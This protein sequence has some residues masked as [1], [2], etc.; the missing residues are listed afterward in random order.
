MNGHVV[1]TGGAGRLGR[2]VVE[3]LVAA[4][5]RVLSVDVVRPE[6][7]PGPFVQADITSA[8]EVHDL[9]AGADSVIHLAAVPGP[10]MRPASA[11]FDINVRSTFNIAQAAVAHRLG[12]IVFASSVFTLGWHEA[13]DGYWPQY[14]PVDEAHPLTP[15]EAYGLSKVVGEE[16][17]AT[18]CRTSG[19]S[20]VSLRIM[21]V[22]QTDGYHAL[23]WATPTPE[24]GVRFLM[25]PYV[26]VRDAADA[27]CQALTAEVQGHEALYIAAA[28]IRFNAQTAALLQQFAPA[29]EIRGSLHDRA[30][31]ISIDK[32]QALI[33]YEP[34]YDWA[35][36]ID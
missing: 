13:A 26:D 17:C 18:A 35:S 25:W 19:V 16:I 14:A 12:R 29:V 33:G 34:K 11:T 6:S 3:K 24:A 20:A 7:C 9:L 30:S 15:L 28:D 22:I 21:N 32:A 23:P 4:G 8:G 5:R 1:V 27:C 2:L 31:V 36:S 10:R